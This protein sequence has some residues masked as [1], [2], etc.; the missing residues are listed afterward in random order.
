M[1]FFEPI[2]Q[3]DGTIRFCAIENGQSPGACVLK[4]DGD[5]ASIVSLDLAENNAMIGEGLFRAAFNYAANQ[6]AYMGVCEAENAEAVVSRMR[7]E[8]KNGRLCNDIPT[9]LM[10]SCGA[11]DK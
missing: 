4:L 9:L 2:H 5:F 3:Q 7:F 11:F 8:R 6:G 10:G 1:I